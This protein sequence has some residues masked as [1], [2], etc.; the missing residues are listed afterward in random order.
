[1]ASYASLIVDALNAG[2]RVPPGR[3]DEIPT[4]QWEV[5]FSDLAPHC[6]SSIGVLP[7]S[8]R[9]ALRIEV[10]PSTEPRCSR[11]SPDGRGSVWLLSGGSPLAYGKC[12]M[13]SC[14]RVRAPAPAPTSKEGE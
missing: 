9:N 10:L 12:E 2:R 14:P 6:P 3:F 5:Y 8:Q 11:Q 13:R 1:M 7:E 4:F